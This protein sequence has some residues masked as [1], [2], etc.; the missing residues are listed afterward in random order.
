MV[1]IIEQVVGTLYVAILIAR[2]AGIYP[3]RE[4]GRGA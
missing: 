3:G 4:A 2:L 1:A